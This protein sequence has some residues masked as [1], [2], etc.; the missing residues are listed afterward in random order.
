VLLP[1]VTSVRNLLI[2][3]CLMVLL[4]LDNYCLTL[5][6]RFL[7]CGFLDWCHFLLSLSILAVWFL[8][9][10]GMLRP[11]RFILITGVQ[12]HAASWIAVVKAF[13]SL[14][15]LSEVLSGTDRLILLS[16]KELK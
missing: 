12:F 2:D 14:S 10:F 9:S 4:Y 11:S 1:G 8:M 15:S 3:N 16:S 6:R 13:S 7:L 5:F